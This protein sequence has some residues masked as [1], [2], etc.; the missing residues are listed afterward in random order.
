MT[1]KIL[2]LLLFQWILST[3]SLTALSQR[4]REI[5]VDNPPPDMTDIPTLIFILGVPIILVLGYV[6]L[7][8]RKGK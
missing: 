3:S 5:Q 8:K 7:R 1:Q 2:G 4:P 6:F